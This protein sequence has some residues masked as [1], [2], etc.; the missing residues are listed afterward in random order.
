VKNWAWHRRRKP[1]QQGKGVEVEAATLAT[2]ANSLFASTAKPR[3]KT[4]QSMKPSSSSFTKPGS[5]AAK[6]SSA[7]A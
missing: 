6:P 5:G 4:P 1:H 3:A 2:E 7:A